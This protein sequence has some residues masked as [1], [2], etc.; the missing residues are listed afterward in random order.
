VVSSQA[1]M[2][3][4]RPVDLSVASAALWLAAS[5]LLA[6]L[7]IYFVGIDQGAVSVFGGDMHVHEFTHDARHL[8]AF[9][10]H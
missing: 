9:P 6:L 1:M 10:C 3:P 4:A 2:A 5:T 8:L 7:V